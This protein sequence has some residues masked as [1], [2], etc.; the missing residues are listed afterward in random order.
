M[1]SL[2]DEAITGEVVAALGASPDVNATN[3]RVHTESGWVRLTGIVDTLREKE[4]AEEIT[5]HVAGVVGVENDLTV[6]SDKQISDSEIEEVLNAKLTEAGLSEIGAKV[7]AGSAFLMGVIPSLAVKKRAIEIA[8][9]VKGVREVVSEL[10]I[11]AGEPI[12]D[13]TLADDVAEALSDDPRIDVMDLRVRSKDGYVC[14]T[15]EVTADWQRDLATD[16]AE[17]VPGVKGVENHL[18]VHKTK[19]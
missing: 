19:F 4:I 11:A 13:L 12:D 14:I 18:V 3:I 2:R 5:K 9:S 7:E 10:E 1:V 17:A 16:I 15:G 8:A 6:G